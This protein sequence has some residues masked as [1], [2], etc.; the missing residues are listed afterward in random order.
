MFG[1]PIYYLSDM[2]INSCGEQTYCT[3]NV[4]FPTGTTFFIAHVQKC[5]IW[6]TLLVI[7]EVN[8]LETRLPCV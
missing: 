1:A 7:V 2:F 8:S 6:Y 4:L 3:T 5:L